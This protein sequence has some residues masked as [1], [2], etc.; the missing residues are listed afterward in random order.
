LPKRILIAT[1][2]SAPALAAVE[3]GIE[4]AAAEKAD[5]ILVHAS[6]EIA[7]AVFKVTRYG[8]ATNEMVMAADDA[9]R[10]A[11]GL[12]EEKGVAFELEVIG[13]H[14]AKDVADAIVG[15]AAGRGA[16]MIVVG[17]RGHGAAT[18]AA[19]GSVSLEIVRHAQ[20]PVTVVHAHESPPA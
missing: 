3:A 2:G 1:D 17:S 8:E 11:A 14:G 4:L 15:T 9:L 20:I 18:S 19:F 16:D 10:H 5:V 6:P 12:A 13:E 7:E